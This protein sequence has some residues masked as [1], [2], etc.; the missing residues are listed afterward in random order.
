MDHS[1]NRHSDEEFAGR[2][3]LPLLGFVLGA[4]VSMLLWA[5][6]AAAILVAILR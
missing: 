2:A 3:E 1:V 4:A 5:A 6:V